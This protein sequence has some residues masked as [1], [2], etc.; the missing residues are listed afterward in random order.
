MS[1]AIRAFFLFSFAQNIFLHP[2]TFCVLTSEVSCRQH[3]D[4]SCL[5]IHWDTYLLTGKFS[6]FTLQVII[7]KYV[8]IAILL[9]VFW[10]VCSSL[11]FSSLSLFL[12]G[13]M[14][15]FSVMFRF[16]PHFFFFGEGMVFTISFFFVVTLR[17]NIL[18]IKQSFKLIST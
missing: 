8:L 17:Y 1:I 16:L 18:C 9:T 4:G 10:L 2:F 14:A 5:F 15:F 7:N 11:F 3:T 13:L 6:L 12:C